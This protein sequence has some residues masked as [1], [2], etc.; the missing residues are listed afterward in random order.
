[1]KEQFY[2]AINAKRTEYC[3]ERE[4]GAAPIENPI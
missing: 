2:L 3:Y 4:I 1:M